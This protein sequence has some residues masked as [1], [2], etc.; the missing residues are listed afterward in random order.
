MTGYHFTGNTL[1]NGKPIPPTGEWLIHDGPIVPCRFGLHA[2]E[3]PLDALAYA[4]GN[5]LHRVELEGDLQSHGEP[6][7]KWVG[8][9]RKI[10]ATIDAEPLLGEFARWCALQVIHL[11]EASPVVREY[12]ET[13]NKSM[14]ATAEAAARAA[15]WD[16]SRAASRADARDAAASA[17][18][19]VAPA[20]AASA[21]ADAANASGDARYTAKYAAWAASKATARDAVR[22]DA[23]AWDTAW[24]ASRAA[25]RVQLKQMVVTAFEAADA[26]KKAERKE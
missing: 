21:A 17:A 19:A 6:I 25:Q 23:A 20:A 24:G 14:R 18:D 22:A 5:L 7:D 10:V 3:H 12:L 15:A 8:R 11:W 1:R 2:S 9:Q 13:G 26:A 4:P 16:A